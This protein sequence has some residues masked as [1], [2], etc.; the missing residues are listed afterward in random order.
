MRKLYLSLFFLVQVLLSG[1]FTASS[2]CSVTISGGS[3]TGNTLLTS[4]T[5]NAP[6]AKIEW[7]L[8]GSTL[9]T[10][11]M[12][13]IANGITVAGGNGSGSGANQLSYP[14]DAYIDDAANVYI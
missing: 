4:F 9:Q 5:G 2:Q 11:E 6:P 8:N 14:Y 3:C 7:Q 12:L 10:N 1:N 13:W